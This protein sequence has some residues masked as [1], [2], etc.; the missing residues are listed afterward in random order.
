MNI[1]VK[2][3]SESRSGTNPSFVLVLDLSFSKICFG[4][5]I[6]SL[7]SLK[8]YI[9]HKKYYFSKEYPHCSNITNINVLHD[10]TSQDGYNVYQLTL[11]NTSTP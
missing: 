4:V 2:R 8:K 5:S 6:N 7:I 10:I 9:L 11:K 3:R 1:Q